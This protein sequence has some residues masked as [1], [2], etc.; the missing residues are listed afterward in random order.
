[1]R[2][3]GISGEANVSQRFG[4]GRLQV[5]VVRLRE[6]RKRGLVAGR[7]RKDMRRPFRACCGCRIFRGF[8][9]NDVRVGAAEAERL[10]PAR[11]TL[12]VRVHGLAD[13]AISSG[14]AFQSI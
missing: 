5:A 4:R 2:P 14:D 3:T 11:R 7:Q 9:N 10:T 1:M 6:L 8:L 12:A 13:V